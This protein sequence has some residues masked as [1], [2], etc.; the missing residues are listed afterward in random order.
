MRPGGRQR[1]A[2]PVP[3]SRPY[4][5]TSLSLPLLRRPRV[6][7]SRVFGV[8][9]S[10]AAV[11]APRSPASVSGALDTS[12]AVCS[13][14]A[15]GRPD[16]FTTQVKRRTASERQHAV[17]GGQPVHRAVA[18]AGLGAADPQ[19][20][21]VEREHRAGVGLLRRDGQHRPFRGLWQPRGLRSRR[22]EPERRPRRRSTAAAPGSPPGPGRGH[23]NAGTSGP[24]AARRRAARTRAA[25]ARPPGRC[26]ASRAA[27]PTGAQ[28][29]SPAACPAPGRSGCPPAWP[30]RRTPTRR[31]RSA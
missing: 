27:P 1:S 2:L 9:R 7:A 17:R 11:S 8:V 20:G 23:R 3:R 26:R 22:A 16:R 21:A 10:Q 18:E 31:G 6:A 15:T 13:G 25:R 14:S 12:T 24:A 5:W 30:R 28:P 19:R 4:G 29:L